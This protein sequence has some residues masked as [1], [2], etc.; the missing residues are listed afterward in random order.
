MRSWGKIWAEKHSGAR[1]KLRGREQEEMNRP[2]ERGEAG[3]KSKA[4]RGTEG[5]LVSLIHEQWGTYNGRT[6]PSYGRLGRSQESWNTR[7]IQGF[8]SL[9]AP[10]HGQGESQ[11]EASGP[12]Q[13]STDHRRDADISNFP[14]GPSRDATG[15]GSVLGKRRNILQGILT[16]SHHQ[17]WVGGRC[18]IAWV[19]GF[20]VSQRQR[21]RRGHWTVVSFLPDLTVAI[22]CV[23]GTEGWGVG[24]EQV[25]FKP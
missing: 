3:P 13:C 10:Y 2:W 19:S 25:A 20:R 8:S 1:E 11:R 7:E 12:E 9:A 22:V 16:V 4:F 6:P 23:C 5:T 14:R 17:R 21:P 15:V 24:G 18:W